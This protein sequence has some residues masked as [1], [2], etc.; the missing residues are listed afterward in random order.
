[1]GV[2]ISAESFGRQFKCWREKLCISSKTGEP[3]LGR[4]CCRKI[5]PEFREAEI[6]NLWPA[7]DLVN[8]VIPSNSFER[9]V[10]RVK[11]LIEIPY[12]NKKNSQS[13]H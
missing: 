9:S 8:Q 1:M 4:K 13:S 6:Y 3:Y 7:V 10:K 2:V 11:L 12:D 5:S